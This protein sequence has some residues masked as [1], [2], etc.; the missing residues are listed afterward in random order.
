MGAKDIDGGA[1]G[2]AEW[3]AVGGSKTKVEVVIVVIV[4]QGGRTHEENLK[5]VRTLTH[6]HYCNVCILSI[7][8]SCVP[9]DR[10]DL[11]NCDT[12]TACV[13]DAKVV[14]SAWE[15]P[16]GRKLG[17]LKFLGLVDIDTHAMIETTAKVV[18]RARMPATAATCTI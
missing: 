8:C 16:L 13:T 3:G 15:P 5:V 9:L 6:R 2:G 11:V 10:L 18:L 1:A 14:L 12:I 7:S 4:V 17:P